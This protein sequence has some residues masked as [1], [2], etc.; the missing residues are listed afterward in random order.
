MSNLVIFGLGLVDVQFQASVTVLHVLA[1]IVETRLNLG[2]VWCGIVQLL[3][4]YCS[5]GFPI[6][7]CLGNHP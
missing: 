2:G 6:L 5:S 7:F 3:E 4:V 1:G